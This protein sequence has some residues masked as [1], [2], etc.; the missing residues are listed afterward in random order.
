MVADTGA[1]P[2]AT[3]PGR[4]EARASITRTTITPA[5][6]TE[7]AAPA[8]EERRS[9]FDRFRRF[10][11]GELTAAR[12]PF[13]GVSTVRF[14][15]AC[16]LSALCLLTVGGAIL[17]LLLWQQQRGPGVLTTQIE[18]TWDLFDVLRTIERWTA[19]AT[20]PV[21]VAWIAFATIN[22][23][24]GTGHRR[25]PVTAALSLPVGLIGVWIVGSELVAKT[26]D[27]LAKGA[28]WVLQAVFMA[29]PLLAL[30]RV[31][32]S[33]E[34]RHR[35]LR[36]AY[37]MAIA[38]IAH[39]QFLGALSTIEE[40]KDPLRWGRLGAYL[41]IAG[42][43]QVVGSLAVNEAARSVEEGAENRYQLRNRFGESLLAQ[44]ERGQG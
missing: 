19:F 7:I 41:V 23:R 25:N 31:T 1:H 28:G 33:A 34:G 6:G 12:Q 15:L 29:I 11:H 27:P 42:L 10:T 43:I 13:T 38:L 30:E 26:D 5:P 9:P 17:V 39:L 20:V 4:D 40:T 14:V 22:V 32:G 21:A 2:G 35:P 24:R 37:L 44:A 8:P 16:M 36:V 3:T 18:R